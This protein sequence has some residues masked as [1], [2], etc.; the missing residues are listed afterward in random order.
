[1]MD[2]LVRDDT[3]YFELALQEYRETTGDY[4]SFLDLHRDL[5]SA[6]VQRAQQLKQA[7]QKKVIAA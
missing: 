4:A 1:M 7:E 6:I 2:D 5:Q 3:G